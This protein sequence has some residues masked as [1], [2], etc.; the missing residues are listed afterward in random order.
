MP[1]EITHW[2]LAEKAYGQLPDRSRLKAIIEEHRHLYL[3]GAVLPDAPYVYLFGPHKARIRR[4]ALAIHDPKESSF[5]PLR[6]LIEHYRRPNVPDFV[7][8]LIAGVV[9]HFYADATVHPM[10]FYFAGNDGSNRQTEIRHNTIETALDLHYL[11]RVPLKNRELFFVSLREMGASFG[12]LSEFLALLLGLDPKRSAGLM[13]RIIGYYSLT[14][15][16]FSK[17]WLLRTLVWLNG[18]PGIDLESKLNY[19]YPKYQAVD[20]PFF[21]NEIRYRHPVTGEPQRKTIADLESDFLADMKPLE[22]LETDLIQNP[23][24]E[25]SCLRNRPN[26][27]TGLVGATSRDM[28]FFDTAY[29]LSPLEKLDSP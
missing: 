27:L 7:W 22:T 1:K 25:F 16:S 20:L 17:G 21:R 3:I 26:L 11:N 10:V 13:K 28:R 18:L 24:P 19:F 12:E 4:A 2:I 9:A 6:N 8:A 15:W 5:D 29:D 23:D 14:Q